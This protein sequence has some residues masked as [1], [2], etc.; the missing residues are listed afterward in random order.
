ML[1]IGDAFPDFEVTGVS[2]TDPA[3]AFAP[4]TR[5]DILGKWSVVF[6]WPKASPSSA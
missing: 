5:N 6:F 4:V 1:S 3:S 2:G